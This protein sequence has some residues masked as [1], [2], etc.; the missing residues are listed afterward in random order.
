MNQQQEIDYIK[1]LGK[2]GIEHS[3]NKPFSDITCSSLLIELG[4][5]ISLLP[6]PPAK[7]LDLGCGFGWA[8]C[9]LAKKGYEVLGV[10]IS[11]KGIYYANKKKKMENI[12]NLN[13]AVGDYEDIYFN[14]NTEFN[15]KFDVVIFF[16]SLHHSI[17]EEKALI[18]AYNSL[19]EKGI[20]ITIEPG[21]NHTKS[22]ETI[23]IVKKYNTIERN[24]PPR[25]I[26][27]TGRGIG[28]KNFKIYPSPKFFNVD[29]Y[30]LKKSRFYSRFI[31][32]LKLFIFFNIIPYKKSGIVVMEK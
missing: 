16:N 30:N 1:K 19:K 7:I 13:F 15:E 9:F 20:C 3:M 24:M 12:K 5:I 2:K 18:S 31:S 25:L 17:D 4:S 6:E 8:S 11:E 22:L 10:D 23:E 27:K 21:E 32:F 28:F 29:L 14:E 26:I